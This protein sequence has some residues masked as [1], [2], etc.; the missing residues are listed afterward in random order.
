MLV[1]D[2]AAAPSPNADAALHAAYELLLSS[3]K[4]LNG[5]PSF[6]F[7]AYRA[8][9]TQLARTR[10]L[11]AD[12]AAATDDGTAGV[13]PLSLFDPIMVRR[14]ISS[15]AVDHRLGRQ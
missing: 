14:R 7:Q 13:L 2:M 15:Q 1:L 12:V 8:T 10:E 6:V 9:K 5:T 11:W 4:H 3:E